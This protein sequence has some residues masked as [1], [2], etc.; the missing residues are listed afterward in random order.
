MKLTFIFIVTSLTAL[1]AETRGEYHTK[2]AFEAGQDSENRQMNAIRECAV[3]K[4]H[5]CVYPIL[6]HLKK[7]GKE[8][9]TLRRESAN[10]LGRLRAP[11]AR[12]PLVAL[13]AK[14]Q[15]L[16]VKSATIRALGNIG[17]K[18]DIK[19]ISPYLTDKETLL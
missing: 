7:D 9:A 19:T 12:E 17:N 18:A 1:F 5:T 11:E 14:E 10:A 2:R 8:N 6:E 13:L 4:I 16:F 3:S 15:D